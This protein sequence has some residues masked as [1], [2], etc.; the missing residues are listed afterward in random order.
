MGNALAGNVR[1][2]LRG[3]PPGLFECAVAEKL[4]RIILVHQTRAEGMLSFRAMCGEG[5]H[6]NASRVNGLCAAGS[7]DLTG[8]RWTQIMIKG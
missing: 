8:K 1:G 3:Y 4:S 2:L 5:K 6:Q 7:G